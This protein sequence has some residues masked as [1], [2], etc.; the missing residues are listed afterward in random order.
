LF[1][2]LVAAEVLAWDPAQ[3]AILVGAATA[4][5]A[6]SLWRLRDRPAQHL[7]CVAGVVAFLA[8]V[9]AW[10]DGPGMV[11]LVVWGFGL[12]WV[13]LGWRRVVVPAELALVAAPG[14][15]LVAAG[16]TGGSWESFAPLFGLVTAAGLLVAGAVLREFLITG[17][18]VV[19][20]FVYLPMSAAEYFGETVGVPIVLLATGVMLIVLMLYMLRR[21]SGRRPLPH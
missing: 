21:G 20:V 10:V 16:L 18:G 19:G 8:G 11:G 9:S 17:V 6:G 12:V 3:V 15:M 7:A 2:G 4:L 13:V 1:V 5:Y 14:L